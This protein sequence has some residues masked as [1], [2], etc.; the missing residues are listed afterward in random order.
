MPIFRELCSRNRTRESGL[1][2]ESVPGVPC[3][4]WARKEQS[5]F[6]TF[7]RRMPCDHK[8]NYSRIRLDFGE[9]A[10]APKELREQTQ[11]AELQQA[12]T[13]LGGKASAGARC[14]QRE[15]HWAIVDLKG[16]QGTSAPSRCLHG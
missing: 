9:V 3:F 4:L 1:R 5:A 7:A 8:P 2:H 12:S 10:S 15:E 13:S 6:E 16:R 14:Q 11:C